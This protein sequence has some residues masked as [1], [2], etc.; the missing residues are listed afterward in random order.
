MVFTIFTDGGSRGNPGPSGAGGVIIDTSGETIAE[1]SEFLGHQTNNY[2]EYMAL[3][4]TIKQSLTLNIKDVNVFMDSK[5]IVEQINGNYKVKNESLKIIY[6]QIKELLN[7]FNNITF[8]H[9]YR[10]NNKHADMLVNKAIDKG[11]FNA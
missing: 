4:L 7:H 1:I 2:A 8:T 5:L 11:I 6:L 3:L 9:V 10:S